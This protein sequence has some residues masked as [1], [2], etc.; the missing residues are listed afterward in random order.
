MP[1][2]KGRFVWMFMERIGD[3]FFTTVVIYSSRKKATERLKIMEEDLKKL[4]IT[5]KWSSNRDIGFSGEG[6]AY[7]VVR[8]YVN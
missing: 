4:D 6:F 5:V 2:A 7:K 3:G 1:T 8:W